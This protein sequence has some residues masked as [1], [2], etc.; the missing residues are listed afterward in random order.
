MAA[1][2]VSDRDCDGPCTGRLASA[3][4]GGCPVVCRS[5]STLSEVQVTCATSSGSDANAES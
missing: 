4:R 1:N 3:I 2:H 5:P